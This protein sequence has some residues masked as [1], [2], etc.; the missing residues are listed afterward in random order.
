MRRSQLVSLGSVSSPV[1]MRIIVISWQN[2]YGFSDDVAGRAQETVNL[3][4]AFAI[5]FTCSVSPFGG[6]KHFPTGL[7]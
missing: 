5:S 6:P 2:C 4:M 1:K 7:K 3:V